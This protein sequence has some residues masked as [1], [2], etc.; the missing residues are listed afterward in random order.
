MKFLGKRKKLKEQIATA[1]DLPCEAGGEFVALVSF[2]FDYNDPRRPRP[3]M[4]E[5]YRRVPLTIDGE[6][7]PE[8]KW[9]L[10]TLEKFMEMVNSGGVTNWDGT[11]YYAFVSPTE[12]VESNQY[13]QPDEM[14]KGAVDGYWTHV[15]WYNK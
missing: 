3:V 15:M 4:A 11:G 13:A 14:R 2:R 1:P 10:F 7:N 5:R 12:V 8:L 6:P 9:T